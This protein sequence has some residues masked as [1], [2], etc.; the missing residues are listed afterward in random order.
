[1]SSGAGKC[2]AAVGGRGQIEGGGYPREITVLAPPDVACA[3]VSPLPHSVDAL[4]T[5]KKKKKKKK[6]RVN[7][8]VYVCVG[9]VT[10]DS[11]YFIK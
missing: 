4:R 1:M 8:C 7:V 6:E 3:Q 5:D 9:G 10:L 2:P 11:K